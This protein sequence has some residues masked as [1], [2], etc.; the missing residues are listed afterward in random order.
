[1]DGKQ[2]I[3]DNVVRVVC[4]ECKLTLGFKSKKDGTPVE[5][6]N[7]FSDLNLEISHTWCDDCANDLL[8]EVL[9]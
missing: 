6:F 3:I 8:S 4:C 1:M 5:E 9:S 2:M 7:T